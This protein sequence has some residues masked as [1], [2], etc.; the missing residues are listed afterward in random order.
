MYKEFFFN[1]EEILIFFYK[2]IEE[3]ND[4]FEI[5]DEE[6]KKLRAQLVEASDVFRIEKLKVQ[7]LQEMYQEQEGKKKKEI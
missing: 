7:K 2:E 6:N 1:N 4:F 3:N 5:L